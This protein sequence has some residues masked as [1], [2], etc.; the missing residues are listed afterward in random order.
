MHS[1]EEAIFFMSIPMLSTSVLNDIAT[2][3][4]MSKLTLSC[5]EHACV[6]QFL[7]SAS[8]KTCV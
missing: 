2:V 6:L 4:L 7:S 1:F 5:G 8:V 3:Q